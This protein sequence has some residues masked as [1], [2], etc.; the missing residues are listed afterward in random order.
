MV[1]KFRAYY[2]AKKKVYTV[3]NIDIKSYGEI[4]CEIIIDGGCTIGSLYKTGENPD[5][6]LMQS[7]GLKGKNGKEIYCGD[8]VKGIRVGNEKDN[9]EIETVGVVKQSFCELVIEDS[10]GTYDPLL[11]YGDNIYKGRLAG[12]EVIGNIYENP[13]LMEKKERDK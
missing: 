10:Y 11:N 6:I 12:I 2:I 4:L 13:E 5:I 7:T 1:P 8:I 3:S 9:K